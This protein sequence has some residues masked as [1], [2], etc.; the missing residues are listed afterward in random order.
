[1]PRLSCIPKS[2]R[3]RNGEPCMKRWREDGQHTM[4]RAIRYSRNS[5]I[6][7]NSRREMSFKKIDIEKRGYCTRKCW[8]QGWLIP[9]EETTLSCKAFIQEKSRKKMSQEEDYHIHWDSRVKGLGLN[10]HGRTQKHAW[11]TTVV[12]QNSKTTQLV[13]RKSRIPLSR[14]SRMSLS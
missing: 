14:H 3:I 7:Y 5:R 1:M 12:Q 13:F 6:P 4:A 9:W 2:V 10:S 11:K 8:L